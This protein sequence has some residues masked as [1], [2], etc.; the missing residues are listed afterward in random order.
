MRIERP[1]LNQDMH[2]RIEHYLLYQFDRAKRARETQVDSKYVD[3]SKNYYGVPAETTRTVPWYKSSNFV[4]KV[5]RLFVETFT[6][7]TLNIVFATNPLIT[8]KNY[9]REISEGVQYYLHHKALNDWQ[10]YQLFQRMLMR[11]AKN[12]TVVTKTTY[13]QDLSIDV[14]DGKESNLINY[15]GPRT[16]V[17]PFDDI[18][19]HPITACDMSEVEIKFHQIRRTRETAER[20]IANGKW[21]ITSEDLNKACL[22]PRDAKREDEREQAGI[23]DRELQEIQTVE[24]HLDYPI[25]NTG[26]Y[27]SIVAEI[28]PAI[29]KM[30]DLYHNPYPGN[31]ETFHLYTPS[32]REDCIYGES[33][34]EILG[35]SQ[36]ETSQIHNDRRNSSFLASAP[37]FKRKAGASVPN[38]STNWYPGK[39]FDLDDLD[40]F[41]VVSLGRDTGDMI[42]EELHVLSLA[43]RLMGIGPIAQ[44]AAQGGPGKGGIYNT[45]GVMAVMSEGNQR[46]DTNIR[47]AREV[48]S[49]IA[50]CSFFLQAHLA[51][52]DPV[53]G[54][55]PPKYADAVRQ[56]FQKVSRDR[57]RST[58]FEIKASSAGANKE[59][60][61]A[62]LLQ[63]GNFLAQH[64]QTLL[65]LGPQLI[66]TQNPQMQMMLREIMQMSSW[67][68]KRLISAYDEAEAEGELPDVEQIFGPGQPAG[69]APG[70]PG[71]LPPT[72]PGNLGPPGAG[73]S[74]ALPPRSTLQQISQMAGG[75]GQPS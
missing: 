7:R 30:I 54:F 52:N 15:D 64:S 67:M 73:G 46:Q 50:R 48:L 41:D 13:E 68:A 71:A 49:D 9:P 75:P 59:I 69:G 42:N 57:I 61:K 23:Y 20:M 38:P 21:N 45:G 63:M 4:V 18:F 16:R 6:A 24:C 72:G 33:W 66:G 34:S 60:E 11:G 74:G 58:K 27:Y 22:T 37:I 12:G 70:G 26:K 53:L 55:M 32:P 1:T 10:Y 35:Q 28:C 17:I 62:S 51:P 47:D 29:R 40:D 2:D 3:W 44:G 31:Y 43:E 5:V 14:F 39:V 56:A 25:A 8:V 19:F 36:E 65:Q